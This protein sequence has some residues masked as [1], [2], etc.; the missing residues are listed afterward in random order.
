[1]D[2]RTT[3]FP[4]E[5]SLGTRLRTGI[6][7]SVVAAGFGQ[8]S[9]FL[10]RIVVANL[11]GRQIFGEYAMIQSTV[12]TVASI[13]QVATGYTAT[14]YVAEFRSTDPDR[15]GRI[16]GLCGLVATVSA[17]LAALALLAGASWLAGNVLR[18]PHLAFAIGLMAIVMFFTVMNGYQLGALAGLESYRALAITGM[19]GG[20]ASI[21]ICPAAAWFGGL[22][23]ILGG[24]G[25][26]SAAQWLVARRLLA[27][28]TAR[29]KISVRWRWVSRDFSALSRFTLPAT[30]SGLSAV[31]AVWVA[32]LFL[33]RQPGGYDQMA[34]YGAA[35]SFKMLVL[36]LPYVINNVGL[37]VL[38]HQRGLYDGGD[39]R[40]LF[41]I[42]IG[43]TAGTVLLGALAVILLGPWLVGAFGHT[44][45]GAYPV[46]VL[47][48]LGTVSEALGVATYQVISV[49]EKIWLSLFGIVLPRDVSIVL[50]SYVLSPRY[51][52]LGLAFAHGAGSMLALLACIYLAR[53]VRAGLRL[54][55]AAP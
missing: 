28:E 23:W 3:L 24:L 46:L 40:R 14:R 25:A 38:S 2:E 32:Q 55:G 42:N 41:R 37:S 39:Y 52:A 6:G 11:L 53:R 29:R 16:L 27:W 7:W 18:A 48:M 15:A 10:I 19:V 45:G 9:T 50:L 47:L 49:E 31:P 26:A 4:P 12:V 13:A 8:G 20:V 44:F 34:L 1:M 21:T 35:N 5:P 17:C 33:V 43:L 22:H 30:L 54:G 51:G 36:F